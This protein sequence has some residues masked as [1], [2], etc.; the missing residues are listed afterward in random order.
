MKKILVR[1]LQLLAFLF[2]SPINVWLHRLAGA[3]IDK[4]VYLYP[5]V[6]IFADNIVIGR[7]AQIKSGTMINVRT[8]RLGRKSRIG[9]FTLV[10]GES[11][12]LVGDA[13]I[14][15]PKCMI[16]CSRPVVLDYYSGVGPGSYLY[17]H[18]SG[19]PVTEGY[20]ATFAPI[21]LKEKVW[22]NMHS[23]IGAGVTI[24]ERSIVLPGTIL[25]ESVE[26]KRIVSGNPSKL[27]NIPLFLG[28][29]NDNF[30]KELA[31]KILI[32]F[33]NWS[34]EFKKTNWKYHD[35]VL[36]VSHRSRRIKITVDA[37]GDIVLLTTKN[38]T[39]EKVYFNLA[40]LSTDK[41]RDPIKLKIESFM[42][43]YYGL[44]FL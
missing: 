12:L 40:D 21:H 42:R 22:V 41:C 2:P 6:L 26:S 34:N 44:I 13:C 17:T 14:I 38:N 24:G 31:Q 5:A 7:D 20:R 18:G 27:N 16:N 10:N 8:F 32:D 19:M 30:I 23:T 3:K 33:C 15:G 35:S 43:L 11:D 36:T 29:T 39:K 25:L 28:S 1:I 4:Y 37:P 9:F